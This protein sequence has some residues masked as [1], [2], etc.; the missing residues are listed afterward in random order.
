MAVLVEGISVIIRRDAIESKYRGGW[1]AFIDDVPN[2]TLCVDDDIARIGFMG[3]P[4]VEAFVK[5][6]ERK[7]LQFLDGGKPVD[8]AIADQERGLTTECDW[9][10]FG[11]LGFQDGG[12]VSACWFFDGPRIVA[13]V[14]LRG[15]S[16]NLATPTD[17][18]FEG[19][20]SQ[21]FGF[22]SIQHR[23]LIVD[24]DE[25]V[26]ETISDYLCNEG[27]ET[28]TARCAE[29]ALEFLAEKSVDVVTT[30]VNQPLM[31][32]LEL[33]KIIKEKYNTE[34]I[35]LTGY[36]EGCSYEKA[37]TVGASA[38]LYKPVRLVDLL[39]IV[40]EVLESRHPTSTAS[41]EF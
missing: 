4:D 38:L 31:S 2:S 19:S 11:K 12:K 33:T 20:L 5:H 22:V 3:P 13:G 21:K 24:D 37:R 34:V 32:G 10:E 28:H 36:P 6:I 9:L 7:G 25:P 29:E 41:N 18:E 8:L 35:I 17:W 39:N 15:S 14:H 30:D 27:Y 40:K 1:R 23:I 16:M 26:R